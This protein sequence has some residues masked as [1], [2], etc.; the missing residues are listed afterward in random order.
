ME[1][2]VLVCMEWGGWGGLRR[3]PAGVDVGE[4]SALRM[5]VGS[6]GQSM[7]VEPD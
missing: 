4:L 2:G 5:C 3:E 6:G 1:A 7:G